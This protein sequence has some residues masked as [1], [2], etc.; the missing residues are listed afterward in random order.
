MWPA[1]LGSESDSLL[2]GWLSCLLNKPFLIVIQR[3]NACHVSPGGDRKQYRCR[4]AQML[5]SG[6]KGGDAVCL[7]RQ[8]VTGRPERR[9][10]ANLDFHTL[11]PGIHRCLTFELTC[12]PK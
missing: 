6:G 3:T 7:S 10:P 5:D 12:G 11:L 2:R 8:E 1:A 9:V 4:A